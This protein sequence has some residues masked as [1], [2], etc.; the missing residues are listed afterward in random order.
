M[1]IERT[2]EHRLKERADQKPVILLVGPRATG[3]RELTRRI[4]PNWTHVPLDRSAVVIK[5]SEDPAGFLRR[6]RA[7][8]ILDHL[9]Y[10][11]FLLQGIDASL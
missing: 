6:L 1:W 4:F 10:A 7:P 8:C 11:P 2:A 5:A 9:Q 3:K